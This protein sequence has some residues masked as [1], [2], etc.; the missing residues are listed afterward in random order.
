MLTGFDLPNI[1]EAVDW[2]IPASVIMAL[3]MVVLTWSYARSPTNNGLRFT[4]GM[5]KLAALALLVVCLLEPAYRYE[6]PE[7]GANLMIV[8][9]DDSQSL[10]IKDQGETATRESRLRERLTTDSNWLAR[11]N[12]DFDVRRYQFDRQLRPVAS[13][14]NYRA[15]EQGSDLLGN[16]KLVNSRFSG[17]P[18]AGVILLTDGNLTDPETAF[19]S[20]DWENM[21]PVYPVLV[22]ESEP[23]RDLGIVRVTS[24][25]TNFETSPVTVT[26][27]LVAHGYRG[28]R[29]TIQLLNEKGDEVGKKDVEQIEDG[30][31]FAVRFRV[32]PEK[33]G[34]NLFRVKAFA[35]GEDTSNQTIESSQEATI[36]NNEKTIVVDRGQGPFRILYVSGR[37]NWEYKFLN[38][39]VSEDPELHVVP[40]IR[41]AKREAKFSFRG[42]E[43]QRSNALFRGFDTQDED[44]TEQYDEPVF[45]RIPNRD[46]AEELGVGFPKD[47][48]TL[49]KFQAVILDDVEAGFFS[50]DQ[51]S[52]LNRFVSIRGGGMLML[53]GQ[54]SF[55]SGN[56]SQSQIG[57]ML[58]IYLDPVKPANAA[59]FRLDLTRE[60]WLEP[61]VRIE[62]TEDDEEKRLISMPRFRT[63]NATR[64][65]K[66]GATVLATVEDDEREYPALVV[67]PFGK[68]RVAAMMVGDLWRWHLKSDGSNDDLLKSWRQTLRW[69]VADVDQRV[70]VEIKSKSD[71][72]RTTQ[73]VTRVRDEEYKLYDNARVSVT[74]NTPDNRT[75]Q[76]EAE[77]SQEEAGTYLTQ[78]VSKVP[79]A[80]SASI[81][82][83]GE[84]GSMIGQ[85]EAGWVSDLDGEEFRSLQANQTVLEQ[86]AERTGGEL[87]RLDDLDSFVSSLEHREVPVMQTRTLPWWHRWTI[88][89]VAVILLVAEWGTRRIKGL[90]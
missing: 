28:R 18:T 42:R 4:L 69:L 49:F 34:V 55:G 86:I 40:L 45:L 6:R 20:L 7:P 22:G 51:K 62:A 38:R 85:Q 25:Q 33:R 56:Y 73:I 3:A 48:E 35:S 78:F 36:V 46:D 12:T 26:A 57:E 65:I 63:L 21:P 79:G 2:L 11:M 24:T 15:T 44:T 77:P 13:F 9:A 43:G 47:A 68:G 52:L 67:Q 27:E 61:W 81:R 75:I 30:K 82:S 41:I 89:A 70:Q 76:L 74:I 64:S 23:A 14:S 31:A 54:E 90:P 39:A 37:P 8:M 88:F 1:W 5:I 60:G 87:L 71:S 17:R 29:V 32:R 83:E 53:G 72:N 16:L 58:P 80:Y 19:E 59:A 50:E 84:D 10:Q 66:P